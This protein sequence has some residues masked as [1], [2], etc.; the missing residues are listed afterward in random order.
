MPRGR[1]IEKIAAALLLCLTACGSS[2]NAPA[3][4]D[5][6]PDGDAGGPST[7][8]SPDGFASSN[9][10]NDPCA[11]DSDCHDPYLRCA[12]ATVFTCRGPDGGASNGACL[13]SSEENVPIC[14]ATGPV[15]VKLC[16]VS[17]RLPCDG[18]TDCG[19]SG[20]G[21]VAG[22]C[23]TMGTKLCGSTADCPQFWQCVAPCPCDGVQTQ[24]SACYPPFAVFSCPA[25]V[26]GGVPDA[27][28]ADAPAEAAADAPAEA[29]AADAP[30]EAASADAGVEAPPPGDAGS[31]APGA[32]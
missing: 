13:V 9:M 27:P 22:Q 26:D 11:V 3:V 14:P 7:C 31:D 28:A 12:T 30:A 32:G 2:G 4:V 15:A 21:C 10:P 18:D 29:A 19:P 6:G 16:A 17:Y 25:C 8:G 24:D 20:F 1:C 23:Q 5:A